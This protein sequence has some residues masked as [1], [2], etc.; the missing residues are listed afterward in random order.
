[1]A[2]LSRATGVPV[3]TVKYYL[4]EGLL[5]TG[6]PVGPNQA[7]YQDTHVRRLRLIRVLREVGDLGVAQVGKILEAIEAKDLSLPEVLGR[8]QSALAPGREL[9]VVS[10]ELGRAKADVDGFIEELGW[11]VSA[12]A[13]ARWTLAE[14]LLALQRLSGVEGPEV[15]VPYAAAA[16]RIALAELSDRPEGE[17]R[18]ETLERMV[19]G[20][21]VY[22]AA[23]AALR[24]LAREHHIAAMP[25]GQA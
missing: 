22:E 16:E 24:R 21:V 1:M 12:G 8:A 15:F 11:R 23:L 13:P 17:S 18:K 20:T 10:E 5:P 4:R 9:A 7:E 14:A 25:G 19:I 2:E 3:P 6:I